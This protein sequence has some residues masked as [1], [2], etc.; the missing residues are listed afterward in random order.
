MSAITGTKEMKKLDRFILHKQYV[1][2]FIPSHYQ[3]S[4]GIFASLIHFHLHFILISENENS[5][6]CFLATYFLFSKSSVYQ[7]LQQGGH[8]FLMSFVSSFQRLRLL[9]LSWLNMY[10]ANFYIYIVCVCA[11]EFWESPRFLTLPHH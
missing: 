10:V 2:V 9:I 6:I 4:L 8:E 1:R 7:F 5:L 3:L 11:V